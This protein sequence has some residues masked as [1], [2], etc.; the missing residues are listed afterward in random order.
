MMRISEKHDVQRPLIN[1]LIG[2]GW[3]FIP[4]G[5]F[6]SEGWR[7]DDETNPFLLGILRK[8]LAK[9]NG[10]PEDDQRIAEVIRQLRLLPANLEGHEGF[11]HWLR[12]RIPLDDPA[13]K[14]HRDVKLIDYDELDSNLFHFTEE[15]PFFDRDRRRMDM[16]LF[17]N[18]LPVLLVENKN[19][20][21]QDPGMEG[22]QQ[23]QDTY[24]N[25]IPAFLKYPVLFA[26]PAIRLEYGATW[27][28]SVKAFYRWK[29]F[30][31]S[32]AGLEELS[33]GFFDKR[34]VL[35]FI[36][37]YTIF[38][39]NDDAV[40]KFLLRPHQI[41]TVQK[42]VERV[43]AGLDD[44]AAADTGLE[45]H[46]QG[47]GKTLTMIVTAQLLHRHPALEN[48]TLLIVVD[49][50]E[51]E[52]Q[53]MQSLEAFGFGSVHNPSNKRKLRQLLKNGTQGLIVTTI[54]KFDDMPPNMITGRKVV[55]LI[56]EAHRSQEGELGIYLNGALPKAFRFGF[57]GTPIDRGKVGRGTFELFRLYDRPHGYH[58]KYSINESIED[59]TTVPLYYTPTPS[60]IWVDKLQLEVK[61]G[62]L[63]DEFLQE[64]D[65]VGVASI[66]A[67]NQLLKKAD[68]LMAV[69]KSPE[70]I[71]A[72]T[73]DIAEH[74]EKNV[75][76]LGF[77]ALIVTPDR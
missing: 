52:S 65:E 77:K 26:V 21:S 68:K 59:K 20:K 4:P 25:R 58:D 55:I 6:K 39:R 12:G 8:Q 72:I 42:I 18:G 62:V 19:P 63:L 45:W 75:L 30:D 9:L 11:V 22:F 35:S 70:R 46:T 76:P 66:D 71:S 32:D 31:G 60:D 43:V 53:M 74:F 33:K 38:Y 2:I 29:A 23:V 48:P 57:T 61:N 34:M 69:L 47:S 36:R 28:P 15:M 13:E 5:D 7:G 27:N 49:R 51:L 17:V 67:L 37:D 50:V 41:R 16:V 64:V 56:D 44:L 3:Q 24:T 54:H 73:R 40:Q 10:W 14:L 1:S